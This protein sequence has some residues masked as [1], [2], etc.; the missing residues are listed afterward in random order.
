LL[1]DPAKIIDIVRESSAKEERKKSTAAAA[2]VQG[3]VRNTL[4][5]G[6]SGRAGAAR[7]RAQ[8]AR[9]PDGG[10]H[11]P[12]QAIAAD[13]YEDDLGWLNQA[14]EVYA[15]EAYIEECEVSDVTS[16]ESGYYQ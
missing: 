3:N 11:V 13:R 6:D 10:G 5:R 14:T 16:V 7:R 9:H 4:R 15:A 8:A 1:N 2:A 12:A